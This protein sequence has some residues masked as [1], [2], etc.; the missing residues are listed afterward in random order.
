[1]TAAAAGLNCWNCGASLDELPRP[2]T[3]HMNCPECFE[4]LH[5][6]RMCRHF[7][8]NATNPCADERA[9]PP[10]HKEGANFC[11]FFRPASDSYRAGRKEKGEQARSNLTALFSNSDAGDTP[12][13]DA[14]TPA[15]E[16]ADDA[17]AI[18]RRKL[19]GL[20][21]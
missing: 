17:A 11:D 20:F 19:E 9:E 14:G 10:V 6:C 3:R 13:E 8:D 12:G 7:T 2:I 1:M 4:D 21:R 18:A 5:C 15:E 16:A